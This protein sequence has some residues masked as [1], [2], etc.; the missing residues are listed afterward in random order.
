[1][2]ENTTPSADMPDPY[3][4]LMGMLDG[5]TDVTKTRA[6]TITVMPLMGVGGSSNFIVQTYRQRDAE[7]KS[8]DTIFLVV[9]AP[10]GYHRLVLPAQVADAIARQRDAL[11][12]ISHKRAGRARAAQMKA[13]GRKPN[14]A[15]LAAWRAAGSPRKRKAGRGKK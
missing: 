3:D 1:M 8:R 11:G 14:T 13:E 4:R 10:G 15:G 6:T 7:E 9:A 2:V 12:V 5:L